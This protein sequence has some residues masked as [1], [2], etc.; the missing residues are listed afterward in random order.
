MPRPKNNRIVYEPPVFSNFKPVGIKGIALGVVQLSLDEFEAFRLADRMG[1]SHEEAAE[2]MEI[3]RPTFSRLI[4]K[5][6]K[7]IAEFIIEGKMLSVEGGNIH[8]RNNIIKCQGC[9]HMFRIK[10][11]DTI[12]KC[13]SCNSQN[14][15]NLAGGFGH[16]KCCNLRNQKRG[17]NNAQNESN[18]P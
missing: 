11:D 10:F 13:P 2:E 5:A 18:R 8:F 15:L 14:L 6:R 9:G 1:L 4:D 3:S 17:G 16:G 12:E 7:K